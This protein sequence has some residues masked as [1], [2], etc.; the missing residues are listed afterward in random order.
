MKTHN[1][2][3]CVPSLSLVTSLG[4]LASL[5]AFLSP[6]QDQFSNVLPPAPPVM[7]LTFSWKIPHLCTSAQCG[8]KGHWFSQAGWSK[9]Y[10]LPLLL[11]SLVPRGTVGEI[12]SMWLGRGPSMLQIAHWWQDS[13]YSSKFLGTPLASS[14]LHF[15]GTVGLTRTSDLLLGEPDPAQVRGGHDHLR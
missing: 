13:L 15:D 14:S 6:F 8:T 7:I 11:S 4:N 2:G 9:I 3:F 12:I 5:L 1:F 10:R